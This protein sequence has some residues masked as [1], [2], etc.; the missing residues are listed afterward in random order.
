MQVD[1]L[2]HPL[3]HRIATQMMLDPVRSYVSGTIGGTS[4]C[5]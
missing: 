1:L 2:V 5:Q 4:P 3:R